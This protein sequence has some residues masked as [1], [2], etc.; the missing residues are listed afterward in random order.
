VSTSDLCSGRARFNAED[1]I[2]LI[3]SHFSVVANVTS[4]FL[5]IIISRVFTPVQ[6][7]PVQISRER[8]AAV[9]I[10]FPQEPDQ[11]F[12]VELI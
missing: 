12:Y 3:V 8:R 4:A 5:G 1:L 2:S 10:Y 6:P 7:S 9:F 11:H